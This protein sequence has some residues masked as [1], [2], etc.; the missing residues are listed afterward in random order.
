MQLRYFQE[1]ISNLWLEASLRRHTI[2]VDTPDFEKCRRAWIATVWFLLTI[3]FAIFLPNIG[4]VIKLLGS[5]AAVFVFI[6][7]GKKLSTKEPTSEIT[8][9]SFW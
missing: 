8:K 1:A 5:L 6:F 2:V 3:L 7:P 9:L 4:V